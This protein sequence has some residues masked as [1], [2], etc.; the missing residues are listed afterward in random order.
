[1]LFLYGLNQFYGIGFLNDFYS[2]QTNV[3]VRSTNNGS[4]QK[5]IKLAMQ[6]RKHS[7]PCTL[8]PFQY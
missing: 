1:M 7:A 2:E 5:E 3:G 4:F 8:Y 6:L